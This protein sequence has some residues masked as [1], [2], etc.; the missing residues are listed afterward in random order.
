MEYTSSG[1]RNLDISSLVKTLSKIVASDLKDDII[2][3]CN[4]LE[5]N[6]SDL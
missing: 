5:I 4:E 3:M 1:Y 6:I 2:N